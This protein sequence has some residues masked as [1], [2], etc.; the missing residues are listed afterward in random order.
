MTQLTN[1]K[2]VGE[3]HELFEHPKYDKLNETIF[4]NPKLVDLRYKL[5]KEEFDELKEAMDSKNLVGIADA[6][7]DILYVVY[8]AGHVYG[9][10]L[11]DTF[12]EVHDSNMTKACTSLEQAIE[13][14]EYIKETQERYKD[15][16][17]KL[18]KDGKY[19]IIYDRETGKILKNKY[20]H[21]ARLEFIKN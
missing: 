2:K 7:S 14:V 13:S 17:Y 15:P 3:F 16:A 5:I 8:G 9:I 11:D 21:E 4:D 12:K 18:S 1:F 20:Y 19:Y 10:N 6:L